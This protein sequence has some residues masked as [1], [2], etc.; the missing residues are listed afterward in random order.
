MNEADF[1]SMLRQDVRNTQP[2]EPLY[3]MLKEELTMRRL[4]HVKAKPRG[5]PFPKGADHP[6]VQRKVKSSGPK[7]KRKQLKTLQVLEEE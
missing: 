2:G 4:W 6:N 1:I 5:K 3:E 7:I